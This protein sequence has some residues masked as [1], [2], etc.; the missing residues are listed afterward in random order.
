[1]NFAEAGE[2]FL[3]WEDNPPAHLMLQTIARMLGWAPRPAMA[4]APQIAEIAAA[5]PPGL[6]VT[7]GGDLGMPAPLAI[8]ALRAR[9][10][11]VAT[12]RRDRDAPSAGNRLSPGM[13]IE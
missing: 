2:I 3:Y 6:T 10:R 1:M 13:R 8:D 9:N 5:A 11:A 12:A 7:Q 4:S